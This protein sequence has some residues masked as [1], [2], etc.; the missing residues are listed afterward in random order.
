MLSRIRE[1]TVS[2]GLGVLIWL[3]MSC[4]DTPMEPEVF[5]LASVSGDQQEG[6]PGAR[7]DSLVVSLTD[8]KGQPAQG[9]RVDFEI[10]QGEGRLSVKSAMTDASGRASTV[11]T[12]ADQVGEVQVRATLF[13][14]EQ[15]V[16]FTATAR[17]LPPASISMVR[18]DGQER[19]PRDRLSEPFRVVVRDEQEGPVGEALVTFEVI[20]GTGVLSETEVTTSSEGFAEALLRLGEDPGRVRVR[21]MV[22]GLELGVVFTANS[23]PVE[24]GDAIAVDLAG[25]ARMEMVAVLAGTF[26]MGARSS[27]P[28]A[29]PEEGPQ[30]EVTIT[31]GFYLGK[32]ELTQ[33]QWES[34]MG[35]CPWVDQRQSIY[36]Q[37]SPDHPAVYI[38]W[39]DVQEFA[40]RLNDTEG[41][42]A[43]RLPTEAEWEYACRAGATKRWCFGDDSKRYLAGYAWYRDNA[44]D[45]GEQHSHAVGSKLPNAWGLYDMHGNVGEWCQD[46]YGENYYSVST[47]VDPP[48]PPTGSF[49]VTRGGHFAYPATQVRSAARYS[50]A[51]TGPNRTWSIG[52]RILRQRP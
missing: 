22:P 25:G 19:L 45:A 13:S 6:A 18:G 4:G 21:A 34:V 30:H 41:S 51:P 33:E 50:Q 48:G 12:L 40:R 27:E 15:S 38:S 7:L 47:S 26:M 31:Q 52:A 28:E 1:W 37:E 2:L 16:M 5:S 3:L 49:R 46:W 8:S 42:D 35:T 32:Y 20:E 17:R 36:V 23:L 9:R 14:H 10:V 29:G 11:L 39:N 44:W 43:Y 24:T